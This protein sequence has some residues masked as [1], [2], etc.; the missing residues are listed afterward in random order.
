MPYISPRGNVKAAAPPRRKSTAPL[1]KEAEGDY[2]QGLAHMASKELGEVIYGRDE[3]PEVEAIMEDLDHWTGWT[4]VEPH[5]HH[6]DGTRVYED[7]EGSSLD[8]IED[9]DEAMARVKMENVDESLKYGILVDSQ[10]VPSDATWSGEKDS[11]S[12]ALTADIE[13]EA[14]QEEP[15]TMSAAM[16]NQTPKD[17]V[18][19][20]Q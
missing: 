15:K 9:I 19:V 10:E 14:M 6:Q 16:H 7:D 18:V 8:P 2:E 20:G 1:F 13:M 4:A 5:M 3:D 17:S 11:L 12:P